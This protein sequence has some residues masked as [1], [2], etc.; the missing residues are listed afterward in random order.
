MNKRKM[1]EQSFLD[2][3]EIG[4]IA[5]V[6][7]LVK[8]GVDPTCRNED[9]WNGLIF[10][11]KN[12]HLDVFKTVEK[13]AFEQGHGT[14]RQR[15]VFGAM[16]YAIENGHT[17]IVNYVLEQSKTKSTEQFLFDDALHQAAR[18][19]ELDMVKQFIERGADIHDQSEAALRYAAGNG[20]TDTVKYLIDLGSKVDT[21]N[22]GELIE[23]ARHGHADTVDLLLKN[24]ANVHAEDDDAL[25]YAAI[26]G[27]ADTVKI[28]L[29]NGA[30]INAQERGAVLYAA[31]NGH[32]EVLD[33]YIDKG[34]DIFKQGACPIA[35]AIYNKQTSVAENI[36]VKHKIPLSEKSIEQLNELRDTHK[37]SHYVDKQLN[38]CID[39]TFRMNDK[40]LLEKKLE[41]KLLSETPSFSMDKPKQGL[42]KK[43]KSQGMKL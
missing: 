43:M 39:Q 42:A 6:N 3:C 11:A 33:I 29:E 2:A 21:W 37:N 17:N 8:D 31:R 27:S 1:D 10:S 19:G 16:N 20:H 18:Y 24:G 4:A 30:D 26:K 40:L 15:D 41:S 12:G 32:N 13:A 25:V 34:I 38:D 28:L 23:A 7:S 14:Q 35:E 9:G 22:S 36:I 5:T